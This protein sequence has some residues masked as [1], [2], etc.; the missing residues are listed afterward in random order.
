MI[1]LIF[2]LHFNIL[3]KRKNVNELVEKF[4]KWKNLWPEWTNRPKFIAHKIAVVWLIF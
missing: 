2:N 1:L 3:K 4:V